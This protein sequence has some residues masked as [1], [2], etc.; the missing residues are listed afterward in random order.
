MCKKGMNKKARVILLP[1]VSHVGKEKRAMRSIDV[2]LHKLV[3]TL[4]DYGI[5]TLACCCGH[6]ETKKSWVRIHPKN[7]HFGILEDT[8]LMSI[9]LEFPYQGDRGG[10]K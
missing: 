9:A 4:N 10:L 7:V 5:K 1:I 6:G 2:C 8:G 3:K